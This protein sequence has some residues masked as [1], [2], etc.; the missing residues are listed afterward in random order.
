[1]GLPPIESILKESGTVQ[2]GRGDQTDS[3]K[4]HE[5]SR[6]T[7]FRLQ[8][9]QKKCES[10][11]PLCGSVIMPRMGDEGITLHVGRGDE[12]MH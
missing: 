6:T 4:V 8:H 9:M 10:E 7:Q 1:M 11:Y 2:T 12:E 5:F 3:C